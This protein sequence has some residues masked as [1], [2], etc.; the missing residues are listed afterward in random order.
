MSNEQIVKAAEAKLREVYGI[1]Y[2]NLHLRRAADCNDA[3]DQ[4][5]NASNAL[6]RLAESLKAGKG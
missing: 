3:L 4:I 5:A 2:D 1:I 6:D